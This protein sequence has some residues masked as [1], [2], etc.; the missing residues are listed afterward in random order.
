MLRSLA[1]PIIVSAKTSTALRIAQKT[2]VIVAPLT[3]STIALSHSGDKFN[4]VRAI[5]NPM[6]K[7]IHPTG[8]LMAGT[9]LSSN[10][11]DVLTAIRC[12]QFSK[13]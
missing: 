11:H 3:P 5:N 8:A 10:S 9:I 1:T 13:E 12:S 7:I 6:T 4:I 2:M